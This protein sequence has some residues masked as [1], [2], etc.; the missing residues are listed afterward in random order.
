MRYKI[1]F[2]SLKPEI[3]FPGI[4]HVYKDQKDIRMRVAEYRRSMEPHW[5]EKGH[6]GIM[7]EGTWDIE[8]PGETVIRFEKGDGVFLP[9]GKKHRHRARVVSKKVK[10]FFVELLLPLE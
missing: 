4:E 10:V 8:F 7:L 6:Y 1:D 9:P 2:S 5:C 3:P